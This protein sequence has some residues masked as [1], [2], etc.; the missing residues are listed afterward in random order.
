MPA[1]PLDE[2]Q[3]SLA[4]LDPA[5]DSLNIGTDEL[6]PGEVEL[7]FLIPRAFVRNE[8]ALLGSELEDL[9][10][11]ILGPFLELVTG[12]RP[13]V[14][15]KTIASSDFSILVHLN[16]D[17]AKILAQCLAAIIGSYAN[18]RQARTLREQAK[19][20]GMSNE[21][22]AGFERHALEKMNETVSELTDQV[23]TEYAQQLS[24]HGRE[25]EVRTAITMSLEGLAHRVDM[26][27]NFEIR[28]LPP[29]S[30]ASEDDEEPDTS[31]HADYDS[32]ADSA[33][34]LG[35]M[36]LDGQPILGLGFSQDESSEDAEGDSSTETP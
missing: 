24:G 1:V 4:D 7:G 10:N 6:A 11:I 21:N 3:S 33:K 19:D 29:T 17:V 27:Y 28:A 26:G 12:S 23:M 2:V 5:M 15:L 20:I 31:Q 16:V 8:L 13:D 25:H 32:I 9:K 14:P 22:L 36:N 35:Y 30:E 18:I 34:H